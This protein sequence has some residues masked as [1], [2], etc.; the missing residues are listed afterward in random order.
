MVADGE[1]IVERCGTPAYIAPEILR[2]GG[3]E[4]YKVDVWSAGVVL[5]ATVYGNVPFRSSN[6]KQLQQL[7]LQGNYALK[8]DVS[9]EVRDILRRMLESDPR[10]RITIPQ[11]L[12]HKWFA[13]VD[14]SSP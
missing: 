13:D 7:I 10:K 12:C 9:A 6:M 11:M 2:N 5:Y 3:Y 1:K 8:H 4:G 14:S